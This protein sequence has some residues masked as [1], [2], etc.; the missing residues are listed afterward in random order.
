MRVERA[1]AVVPD[2]AILSAETTVNHYGSAWLIVARMGDYERVVTQFA[3]TDVFGA[4]HWLAEFNR[5]RSL[6]RRAERIS[7]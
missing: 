3:S 5:R 7:T 2:E 4:V 6:E 1:L